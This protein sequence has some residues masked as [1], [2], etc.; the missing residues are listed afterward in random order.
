MR[1][2]DDRLDLQV[3]GTHLMTVHRGRAGP[4]GKHG[5]VVDYR[6]V[7]HAL[8][9]KPMALMSLVYRDQLSDVTTT[10]LLSKSELRALQRNSSRSVTPYFSAERVRAPTPH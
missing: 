9:K 6:H 3:G 2:Y 1:L 5:H 10:Q 7:I 4:D 8:R